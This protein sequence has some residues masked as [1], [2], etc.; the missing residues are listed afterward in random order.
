MDDRRFDRLARKFATSN[1]GR[2]GIIAAFVGAAVWSQ[3]RNADSAQPACAGDGAYC[4]M[5][6]PCCPG[7]VCTVY[8]TNPNSGTCRPGTDTTGTGMVMLG[9]T[10]QV[11]TAQVVAT[12]TPRPTKVPKATKTPKPTK[13]P[14][15]PRTLQTNEWDLVATV[16]CFDEGDATND[17]FV[18]TTTITNT[19][20]NPLLLCAIASVQHEAVFHTSCSP[21]SN[22]IVIAP[23]RSLMVRSNDQSNG[24]LTNPAELFGNNKREEAR[25]FVQKLNGTGTPYSPNGGFM[26]FRA[27]CSQ[28]P[29]YLVPGTPVLPTSIPGETVTPVTITPTPEPS[30]KRKKRRKKS[31]DDR[32]RR[33]RKQTNRD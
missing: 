16:Q 31:R 30:E 4:G 9:P 12:A 6:Q 8:A 14:K 23:G 21:S 5:W 25:I 7:T 27:P 22:E 2:R 1:V 17:A 18:E 29:S 26:E 10:G 33:N 13:T 28:G 19:G 3:A 32:K 24:P 11:I 20:T 15:A